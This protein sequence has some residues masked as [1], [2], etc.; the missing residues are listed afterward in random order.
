MWGFT[1]LKINAV[2]ARSHLPWLLIWGCSLQG[3]VYR[4]S[5]LYSRSASKPGLISSRLL[6]VFPFVPHP[7]YLP[8]TTHVPR[9]FHPLSSLSPT[10]VSHHH[11]PIVAVVMILI[12]AI[13][14]R[15]P[16]CGY[17]PRCF[18]STSWVP[19][20][21]QW[22]AYHGCVDSIGSRS[23]LTAATTSASSWRIHSGR[24]SPLLAWSRGQIF[25]VMISIWV[26]ICEPVAS[27]EYAACRLW[28][29]G[30]STQMLSTALLHGGPRRIRIIQP[31]E[32]T[33]DEGQLNNILLLP[34]GL[35]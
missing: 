22:L 29:D 18:A 20:I 32:I 12:F 10:P 28:W 2:F 17:C 31:A 5:A 1:S 21:N 11:L 30:F 6:A 19:G 3:W 4:V 7:S 34:Y 23:L 13:V 27:F 26:P 14:V 8:P 25:N 16:T 9:L 24:R 35:L 33:G 15:N